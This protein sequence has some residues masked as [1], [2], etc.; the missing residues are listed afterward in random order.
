MKPYPPDGAIGICGADG[1]EG[2]IIGKRQNLYL[3][4]GT[5]ISHAIR[6]LSNGLVWES[7]FQRGVNVS[8][9]A[10]P[11]W[12]RREIAWYAPAKPYSRRQLYRLG[13]FCHAQVGKVPYGLLGVLSL[14]VFG[15][16]KS[17]RGWYCSEA[18]ARSE[19]RMWLP[20][21]CEGQTYSRYNFSG[22][23]PPQPE[24]VDLRHL[25]DNM[26]DERD[27]YRWEHK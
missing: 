20:G 12:Q 1:I 21:E 8:V 23:L 16:N 24:N 5:P 11:R 19:L 13:D 7:S 6:H 3:P 26:H 2:R 18:V 10:D 4:T 15:H 9:L 25:V 17:K 27:F 14:V 22:C